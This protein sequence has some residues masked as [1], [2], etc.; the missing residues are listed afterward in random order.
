M[1]TMDT[2]PSKPDVKL[3]AWHLLQLPLFY[4]V[5]ILY[6]TPG[7]VPGPWNYSLFG[8]NVL[9]VVLKFLQGN[10]GAKSGRNN[11]RAARWEF[12]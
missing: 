6:M 10:K 4:I 3:G 5:Y 1:L 8:H 9:F 7:R 11:N 2:E 12:S